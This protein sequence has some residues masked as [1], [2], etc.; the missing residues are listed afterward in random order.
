[1]KW[2]ILHFYVSC[3][4]WT[5]LLYNM[6]KLYFI[7]FI[8]LLQVGLVWCLLVCLFVLMYNCVIISCFTHITLSCNFSKSCESSDIGV[9]LIPTKL[10]KK[11]KVI[12]QIVSF[13]ENYLWVGWGVLFFSFSAYICVSLAVWFCFTLNNCCFNSKGQALKHVHVT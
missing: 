12:E 11:T 2:I 1:M 10:H 6:N 4:Q 5:I 9:H 7:F 13:S 8:L 3:V